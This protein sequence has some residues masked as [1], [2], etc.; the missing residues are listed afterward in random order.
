MMTAFSDM[1]VDEATSSGI[2]HTGPPVAASSG[3]GVE[4]PSARNH[5]CSRVTVTLSAAQAS[6]TT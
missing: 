4:E 5:C 2:C 6:L 3:R 1:L